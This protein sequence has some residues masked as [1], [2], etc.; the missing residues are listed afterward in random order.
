MPKPI[1]YLNTDL[2]LI[3]PADPSALLGYLQNNGLHAL[4][5]DVAYH[6]EHGRYHAFFETDARHDGPEQNIEAM[7]EVIE[8]LPRRL[9][10]IWRSAE[11]RSFDIGY[12]CGDCG[13]G[14]YGLS[15]GIRP[16]TLRRIARAEACIRITLHS[17]D[18][19]AK[20]ARRKRSR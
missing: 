11:L 19:P 1:H 16:V 5:P 2:D 20:P 15:D 4:R 6:D 17:P 8:A 10:R 9:A 14:L 7:L 13:D 3:F 18:P 12:D